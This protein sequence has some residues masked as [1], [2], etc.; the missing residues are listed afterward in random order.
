MVV[1]CPWHAYTVAS[2]ILVCGTFMIVFIS[3]WNLGP[4]SRW[5]NQS[6]WLMCNMHCLDLGDGPLE[7]MVTHNTL[8]CA[9][10]W[11]CLCVSEKDN[12]TVTGTLQGKS[13]SLSTGAKKYHK[14]FRYWKELRKK[15]ASL[16]HVAS[17]AKTFSSNFY[18]DKKITGGQESING[19]APQKRQL[20]LLLLFV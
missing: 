12:S 1:R 20:R 11:R 15:K 5:I 18:I 17:K 7:A 6:A 16:L 3:A 10:V 4:D 8:L 14:I 2:F 19:Q 13:I 9:S